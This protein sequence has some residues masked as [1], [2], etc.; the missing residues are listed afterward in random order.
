MGMMCKPLDFMRAQI[1]G[2]GFVMFT[3]SLCSGVQ[4]EEYYLYRTEVRLLEEAVHGIV[5][6]I[7]PGTP[8][9]ELGCGSA[10]KTTILLRA[11][12][13]RS[14]GCNGSLEW[15]ELHT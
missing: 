11:M 14:A 13:D 5:S 9:V 10:T 3:G 15:G 12:L 8:L 2:P 4:L 7:P 6:H 1:L